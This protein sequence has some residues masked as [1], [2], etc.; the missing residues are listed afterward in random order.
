MYQQLLFAEEMMNME[1]Q[2]N[3]KEMTNQ[4]KD[5][6][7][8]GITSRSNS[9]LKGAVQ[10]RFSTEEPETS[11]IVEDMIENI[12]NKNN[13]KS[14]SDNNTIMDYIKSILDKLDELQKDVNYLK[15]HKDKIVSNNSKELLNVIKSQL[16]DIISISEQRA[17][18]TDSNVLVAEAYDITKEF[19]KIYHSKSKR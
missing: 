15:K 10:L 4:E 11:K 16:P 7:T 19:V 6:T 2:N 17:E 12:K 3:N 9:G 8:Q 14:K 18:N 5:V 1:E 13:P